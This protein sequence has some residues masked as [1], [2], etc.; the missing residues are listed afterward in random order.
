MTLAQR[1]TI[2]PFLVLQI[3]ASVILLIE[4]VLKV[5]IIHALPPDL[6]GVLSIFLW[7]G[8][9]INATVILFAWITGICLLLLILKVPFFNRELL[10]GANLLYLCTRQLVSKFRISGT[11]HWNFTLTSHLL[12]SP[13]ALIYLLSFSDNSGKV[14]FGFG[15]VLFLFML[16][17]VSRKRRSRTAR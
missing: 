7:F 2:L 3:S 9:F 4:D 14:L 15:S 13:L 8:M 1:L 12:L 10:I 11:A 16:A 17:I 6:I 5:D